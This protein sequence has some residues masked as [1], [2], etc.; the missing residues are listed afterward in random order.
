[1]GTGVGV[2][3]RELFVERA[4]LE[5]DLVRLSTK[6]VVIFTLKVLTG[7]QHPG[8][9]WKDRDVVLRLIGIGLQQQS[10]GECSGQLHRNMPKLLGEPTTGIDLC[11][12]D[13]CRSNEDGIT[14]SHRLVFYCVK[15]CSY[16]GD[17]TVMRDVMK[18]VLFSQGISM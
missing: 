14:L 10:T 15:D 11:S 18:K 16:R 7:I 13:C 1:M 3:E 4:R 6:G 17:T 2:P 5:A 12:N 9:S 8:M